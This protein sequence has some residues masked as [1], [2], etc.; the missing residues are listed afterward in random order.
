[1]EKSKRE[2]ILKAALKMFVENGFER[3][4]TSKIAKDAGVA[5]GTLFHYFNTKEELINVLYL[6]VKKDMVKALKQNLDS[7][8]TLRQK[9][10]CIWYNAIS[11]SL[12]N[13]AG[14]KFFAMYGTSSYIAEATRDEGYKNLEFVI[15]IFILGINEEVLK[16][17]SLA[18]M[19]EI[20]MG[21]I[22]GFVKY[23]QN[24]KTDFKDKDFRENAFSMYWDCIKR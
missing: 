12:N 5:T 17:I 6:D 2:R 7:A 13:P 15:D 10:E 24:N 20:N 8:K 19:M 4:P 18:L 3:S 14:D 22:G 1:M 21:V 11:W 9:I 23:F 16:D